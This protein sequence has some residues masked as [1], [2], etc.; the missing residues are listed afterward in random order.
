MRRNMENTHGFA[1]AIHQE[2]L[3]LKATISRIESS[4]QAV[5][6]Q[7]QKATFNSIMSGCDISDFF[8]VE[9]KEQL[10]RFMDR[11]HPQ[12]NARKLDFYYL[13]YTIAS[14]DR[15]GFARSL[16]KALF[17]RKYINAMKWPSQG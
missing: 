14:T 6:V 10:E 12:W 13:L 5:G 9:S 8:P 16:I 3:E 4:I 1:Q 17:S 7:I 2:V 15:K 11:D